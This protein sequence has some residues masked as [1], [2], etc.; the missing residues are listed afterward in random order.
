MRITDAYIVSVRLNKLTVYFSH[1]PGVEVAGTERG[2]L[3]GIHNPRSRVL[4]DSSDQIADH[5]TTADHYRMIILSNAF[6]M[7]CQ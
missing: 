3:V 4:I 2:I 1:T 7:F 5:S 6:A